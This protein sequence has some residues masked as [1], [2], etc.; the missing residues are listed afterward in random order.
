[1]SRFHDF[2]CNC[3]ISGLQISKKHFATFDF[4]VKMKLVSTVWVSTSLSKSGYLAVSASYCSL[5]LRLTFILNKD[6]STF[7]MFRFLFGF[8]RHLSFIKEPSQVILS[9]LCLNFWIF[10]LAR[11]QNFYLYT[12][13][14]KSISLSEQ[15]C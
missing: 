14:S 13:F 15:N 10:R 1:M 12:F 3:A 7:D 11:S 5:M 4:F 9:N 8:K 2:L 6:F